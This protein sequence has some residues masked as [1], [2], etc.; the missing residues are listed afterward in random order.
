[1]WGVRMVEENT[2]GGQDGELLV[3]TEAGCRLPMID[4]V[5]GR[6]GGGSHN[7]EG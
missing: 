5:P 3:G 6:L 1:M 7:I 2:W 4:R